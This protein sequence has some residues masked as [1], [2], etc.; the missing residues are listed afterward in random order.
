MLQQI[1]SFIFLIIFEAGVTISTDNKT[2]TF[3]YSL[4]LRGQMTNY[5]TTCSKCLVCPNLLNLFVKTLP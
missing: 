4:N 5:D 1:T 2:I 3:V